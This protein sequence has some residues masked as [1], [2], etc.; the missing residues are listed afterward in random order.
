MQWI[1]M[2]Q[3]GKQ[4]MDDGEEVAFQ[5]A[6]RKEGGSGSYRGGEDDLEA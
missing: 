2:T 1:I 3:E 5:P 6:A 4:E